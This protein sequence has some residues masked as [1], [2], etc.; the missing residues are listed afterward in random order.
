M[1]AFD[2]PV[3]EISEAILEFAQRGQVFAPGATFGGEQRGEG[4][5]LVTQSLRILAQ[6]MPAIVI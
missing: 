2:P 3:V 6:A 4:F 5:G 1:L